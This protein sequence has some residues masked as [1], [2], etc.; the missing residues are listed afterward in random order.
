MMLIPYLLISNIV[1]GNI[2][3]ASRLFSELENL[4][5]DRELNIF[6]NVNSDNETLPDFMRKYVA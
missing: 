6:I 5:E 2:K 4:C 3:D 1:S